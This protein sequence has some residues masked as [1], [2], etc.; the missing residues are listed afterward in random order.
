MSQL[1][2][3]DAPKPDT[4]ELVEVPPE[5]LSERRKANLMTPICRLPDELLVAIIHDLQN[6]HHR[7][8]GEHDSDFLDFDDYD[9][10]W[11][12]MTWVCHCIRDLVLNSPELWTRVDSQQ[13]EQWNVLVVSRAQQWGLCI[14]VLSCYLEDLKTPVEHLSQAKHA[15]IKHWRTFTPNAVASLGDVLAPMLS[16]LH[17]HQLKDSLEFDFVASVARQLV[18]LNISESHIDSWPQLLW[19]RL[20]RFRICQ[21]FIEPG[22]LRRFLHGM[23]ELETLHISD[24]KHHVPDP[25]P[26]DNIPRLM[27]LN[28]L[29]SVFVQN[30]PEHMLTLLRHI[31]RL[32]DSGHHPRLELMVTQSWNVEWHVPVLLRHLNDE[33]GWEQPMPL[34]SLFR[35]RS[36]P[37]KSFYLVLQPS[38][39]PASYDCPFAMK[40]HAASSLRILFKLG[41][42]KFVHD[43]LPAI[44]ALDVN[45]AGRHVS[46]GFVETL[47][48]LMS[49]KYCPNI[50]HIR[51]RNVPNTQVILDWIELRR[52]SGRPT[53]EMVYQRCEDPRSIAGG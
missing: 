7:S 16:I 4:V 47:D 27:K 12:Q 52:A 29:R 51:W 23:A 22:D 31:S 3:K 45:G 34:R 25:I 19:P 40:F 38:P 15:R 24:T 5:L 48:I 11:V 35:D 49:L 44:T 1:E 2:L 10:S 42:E 36:H 26:F 6:T 21:T 17:A 37:S 14:S 32:K 30:L 33:W 41:H 28:H 50:T 46:R 8:K 9:S 18:E 43:Y 13:S 20:R 53:P 39:L